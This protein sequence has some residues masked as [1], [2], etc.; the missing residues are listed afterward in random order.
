MYTGLNNKLQYSPGL[1]CYV[2]KI[3]DR[4]ATKRN[5]LSLILRNKQERKL[6]NC[7]ISSIGCRDRTHGFKTTNINNGVLLR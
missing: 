1:H 7:G 6:V 2:T 3:K 4:F 5:R